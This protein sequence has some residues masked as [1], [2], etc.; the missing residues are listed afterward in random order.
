MYSGIQLIELKGNDLVLKLENVELFL[1]LI[2]DFLLKAPTQIKSSNKLAEYMATH[3][4]TIRSI[5]MGILK[6]DGNG[7]PL[8][9]DR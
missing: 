4:R 1:S 3:A 8:I 5:I 7:N 6:D 2:E 9:D